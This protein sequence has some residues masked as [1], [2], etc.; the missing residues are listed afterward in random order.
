MNGAQDLTDVPGLVR[1]VVD[2]NVLVAAAYNP[3]SAS[4][5]VVGACLDGRLRAVV[6]PAGRD[7]YARIIP[8]AV[9][10]AGWADRMAQF[11]AAAVEAEVGP[12]AVVRHVAADP[13]DDA[14]F[15]A[16]VAGGATAVVTNDRPVLD[17]GPLGSVV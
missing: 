12:L 14:L 16:A 3:G 15:A 7:E 13:D 2:T 4:A 9:R 5:R 1:V 6:S 17:S 11:L 8:R 10:V